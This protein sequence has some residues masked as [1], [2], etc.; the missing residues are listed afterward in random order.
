MKSKLTLALTLA[1]AALMAAPAATDAFAQSRLRDGSG[2]GTMDR[3]RDRDM[4]GKQGGRM[5][6]IKSATDTEWVG[7]MGR[8]G[9][10]GEGPGFQGPPPFEK[11]V[12]HLNL[13]PEQVEILQPLHEEF[14]AAAEVYHE[15]LKETLTDEQKGEAMQHIR[16]RVQ[17]MAGPG[18]PMRHAAMQ[19][20][21]RLDL[22]DEQRH[23]LHVAMDELRFQ[24]HQKFEQAEDKEEFRAIAE[25][26]RN[27]AHEQIKQV[28]TAAQYEEFEQLV[29]E[30]R[31]KFQMGHGPHGRRP[32]FGPGGP[33]PDNAPRQGTGH[34]RAR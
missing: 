11:V 2:A 24:A 3:A 1:L 4:L 6:R 33:G 7:R 22:T 21:R 20:L 12:E 34:P 30:A 29:E 15:T 25:D 32:H 17:E 13:T 23:E 16:R 14:R 9:G 26:L 5:Y 19:A 31:E 8:R 27:Q 18:D 28:L 10:P